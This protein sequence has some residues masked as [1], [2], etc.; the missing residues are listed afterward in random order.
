MSSRRSL[1]VHEAF[2]SWSIG[3]ACGECRLDLRSMEPSFKASHALRVMPLTGVLSLLVMASSA[4]A[5]DKSVS[6]CAP[7]GDWRGTANS[8]SAEIDSLLLAINDREGS[9]IQVEHARFDECIGD[10]KV[11]GSG[12]QGFDFVVEGWIEDA[13]KGLRGSVR[14]NADCD[15]GS[16]YVATDMGWGA[17]MNWWRLQSHLTV[18]REDLTDYRVYLA[19]G[20]EG[21]SLSYSTSLIAGQ[22]GPTLIAAQ[23]EPGRP[24]GTAQAKL[25][26]HPAAADPMPG[27]L[28]RLR[29]RLEA[30]Q[31]AVIDDT[32]HAA[33]FGM[34]CYMV[35][36]EEDYGEPPDACKSERINKVVYEG[37]VR[38]PDGLI[39]QYC[40]SFIANVRLQGSAKLADGGYVHYEPARRQISRVAM[41]PT[42]DG[43]PLVPGRTVARDPAIVRGRNVAMRVDGVGA[44]LANDRGGWIKG[45][46]LDMYMGEG[47]VACMGYTNPTAIGICDVSQER[48]PGY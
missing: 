5:S 34:S 8:P 12:A 6:I 43:T 36:L 9:A 2:L 48:C 24:I 22:T 37:A 14:F 20:L 44:V 40:R 33:S 30:D 38:D 7:V 41:P 21:S 10:I 11:T 17:E 27:G 18:W 26:P 31:G 13:C 47:K 4:A 3:F 29:V 16:G 19:P 15:S 32:H 35:A 25:V 28:A 42:A 45:Y 39:G 46:R 23:P 1:R